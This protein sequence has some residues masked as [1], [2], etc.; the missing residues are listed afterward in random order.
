MKTITIQ[1]LLDLMNDNKE[2]VSLLKEISNL[3]N[4]KREL[5]KKII[6]EK[7]P[8]KEWF[9]LKEYD[10][11]ELTLYHKYK[12]QVNCLVKFGA[13]QFEKME[14]LRLNKK[15]R[16]SIFLDPLKLFLDEAKKKPFIEYTGYNYKEKNTNVTP[17]EVLDFIDK[18]TE[19]TDIQ[20]WD[21]IDKFNSII[22]LLPLILHQKNKWKSQVY[23]IQEAMSFY[24]NS[25][26]I[27]LYYEKPLNYS[28]GELYLYLEFELENNTGKL[29]KCKC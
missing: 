5:K 24:V 8:N 6:I 7:R 16:E 27:R 23:K 14:V 9:R 2:I 10:G 13:V 4:Y 18:E 12:G 19:K 28:Y 26:S 25:F 3:E 1:E 29:T 22:Q 21:L 20:T 11:K 15:K 17:K